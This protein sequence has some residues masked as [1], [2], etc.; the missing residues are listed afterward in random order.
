LGLTAVLVAALACSGRNPAFKVRLTDGAAALDRGAEQATIDGGGTDSGPL[1]MDGT[2]PPPPDSGNVGPE[3]QMTADAFVA[4]GLAADGALDR[5]P[6]DVVPPDV[7]PDAPPADLAITPVDAPVPRG[8]GLL[9]NYFDGTQLENGTPGTLDLQRVDEVINFD[10]PRNVRPDP[11]MDHDN[12]SVR[13]VGDVMPL[14]S[15]S[16]TF[17]TITDDGVKLWVGNVLTS[18]VPLLDAWTASGATTNSGS[19]TLTAF[20][21]YPIRMEYRESTQAAAAKLFWTPPGQSMQVVP[22]DCLFPPAPW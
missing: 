20:Q 17:T 7:A 19:K 2:S 12:F 18:D 1:P 15:G 11:I 8:T 3:A 14:L 16:Y 5:S 9:G 10:W 4:D 6:A 22:K 13:W 21:K